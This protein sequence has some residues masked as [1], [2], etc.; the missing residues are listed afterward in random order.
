L[1]IT[2]QLVDQSLY[3]AFGQAQVSTIYTSLNQ[4]HVVMEAASEYTQSPLD[5]KSIYIHPA[6]GTSVPLDAFVRSARSTSPLAVNHDGLFPAVTISFNLAPGVS[7][8][9]ATV[10]IEQLQERLAIPTTVRGG[11]VGTA[12]DFQKSLIDQIVL[13][14][15]ALFTV[16]IVLGVLYESLVHPITILSTLPPAS[17]GAVLALILFRSELDVI[18]LIG[19]VLLIGIVKKNAIMMIDFALLAERTG[20]KN[21]KDAIFE[22][23]L[24]RF[25]PIMMTTLT[26]LLGSLPLALGHGTGSELRRPLGIAVAGGL[27]LSQILTLYTTPVIYLFLDRLRL[28]L[29]RRRSA[30]VLIAHGGTI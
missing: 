16:Y 2:P 24:L 14:V 12:G 7:L 8:G 27:I 28:R 22:A 17:V 9:Q 25:R 30:T 3:G 13:I 26:A 5:L 23:C 19:I 1:G 29:Q 10:A 18:S 6:N 4:Y 21:S 15:M 11:F 20:G